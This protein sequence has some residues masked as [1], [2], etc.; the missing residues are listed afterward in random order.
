MKY[1]YFNFK[2]WDT[3]SILLTN[4]FG[5]WAFVSSNVF[6]QILGKALSPQD[7]TFQLLAD[8]GF[9]YETTPEVYIEKY[10]PKEGK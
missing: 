2:K 4:D 9:V 3:D 6:Q 7:A 5:E 1:N 10:L 8:K